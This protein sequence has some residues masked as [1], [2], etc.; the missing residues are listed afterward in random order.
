M[1]QQL[2]CEAWRTSPSTMDVKRHMSS[3][4]TMEESF[5]GA[6]LLLYVVLLLVTSHVTNS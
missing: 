1:A 5:A 2:H 6:T 3:H 4:C